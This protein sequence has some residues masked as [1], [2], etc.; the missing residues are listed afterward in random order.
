MVCIYR[1][2]DNSV[3]RLTS[4][5]EDKQ[6][7]RQRRREWYIDL[8]LPLVYEREYLHRWLRLIVQRVA[9]HSTPRYGAVLS[10]FLMIIVTSIHG[11]LSVYYL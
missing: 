5:Y 4:G 2:K 6:T 8:L 3:V 1:V 7:S 9:S 10:F 11:A